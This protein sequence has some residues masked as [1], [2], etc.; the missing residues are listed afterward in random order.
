[1]WHVVTDDEVRLARLVERH[2]RFGKTP[3]HARAWVERVDGANA[4]LIEAAAHRADV[5]LDL[6]AWA[7]PP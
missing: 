3:A 2:E 1:M 7:P 5:V 6:T 4:L